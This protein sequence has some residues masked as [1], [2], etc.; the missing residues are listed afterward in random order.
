[1]SCPLPSLDPAARLRPKCTSP[2][3]RWTPRRLPHHLP[4]LRKVNPPHRMANLQSQ[5]LAL[6]D[7]R[8]QP[9][10]LG[11]RAR[12][13]NS[14]GPPREPNISASRCDRCNCARTEAAAGNAVWCASVSFT[15]PCHDFAH[16]RFVT[17]L[18]ATPWRPSPS[19]R[20]RPSLSRH[21]KN[22]KTCTVFSCVARRNTMQQ[23]VCSGQSWGPRLQPQLLLLSTC[24]I[25]ATVTAAARQS[26][27]SQLADAMAACHG[28][29]GGPATTTPLRSKSNGWSP[30]ERTMRKRHD[31][32]LRSHP[33][34]SVS[35]W[36]RW[37][38]ETLCTR[39]TSWR[40]MPL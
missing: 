20:S 3:R 40:H 33:R 32:A 29:L 27:S 35:K 1:M 37:R 23:S 4:Q 7:L 8:L 15:F 24:G 34:P 21:P 26:H 25:S 5:P 36:R 22:A 28:W 16:K 31:L 30:Y 17:S 13:S 6:R 2:R 39:L 14:I 12:R 38:A 11:P 9:A 10:T 18:C 19:P